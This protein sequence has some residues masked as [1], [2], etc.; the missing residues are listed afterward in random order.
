VIS[1]LDGIK[2]KLKGT[3]I[4]VN[5]AKGCPLDMDPDLPIPIY[6]FLPPGQPERHGL[7]GEY[8]D[9]PDLRGAPIGTKID[10]PWEGF[11]RLTGATV[12]H[13]HTL[14]YPVISIP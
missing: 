6:C 7:R 11:M 2:E 3:S 10:A 9:N 1:P 4:V 14:D 5:H 12:R 13:R 8:F